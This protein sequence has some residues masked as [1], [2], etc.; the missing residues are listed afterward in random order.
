[1]YAGLTVAGP[2]GSTNLIEYKTDLAATN[3]NAL[4]T[5]VLPAGPSLFIDP[6]PANSVKRFY[7][8]VRQ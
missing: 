6:N 4:G 1:M 2:P 5:V 8:A 7:R 3:W